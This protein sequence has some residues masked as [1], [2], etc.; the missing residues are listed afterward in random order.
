MIGIGNIRPWTRSCTGWEKNGIK[1][2]FETN[3]RSWTN[4][5]L[6]KSVNVKFLE[7]G[8]CTVVMKANVPILR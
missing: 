7:V 8:N 6:D 4:Y 1:V 2:I 5:G 3:S